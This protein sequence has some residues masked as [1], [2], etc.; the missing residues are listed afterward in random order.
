M[1]ISKYIVN[2]PYLRTGEKQCQKIA[3]QNQ[4]KNCA[5]NRISKD[6]QVK[7]MEVQG[8]KDAACHLSCTDCAL[9]LMLVQARTR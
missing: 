3:K 5:C 9:C 7:V 6:M 2:Y 8:L 1:L 4:E